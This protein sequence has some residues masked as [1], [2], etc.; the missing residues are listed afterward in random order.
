MKFEKWLD[1][2]NSAFND[3]LINYSKYR[4]GLKTNKDKTTLLI[5][6]GLED[7]TIQLYTAYRIEKTNKRLVWATWILALSTIV[8]TILNV[9]FNIN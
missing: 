4:G 2:F 9:F 8:L 6:S 7:K 1:N 5:P 3:S